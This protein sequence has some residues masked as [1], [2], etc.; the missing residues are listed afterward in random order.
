MFQFPDTPTESEWL[1]LI[2][3]DPEQAK[4]HESALQ[5]RIKREGYEVSPAAILS[6]EAYEA[7]Q[8]LLTSA[9]DNPEREKQVAQLVE[10]GQATLGVYPSYSDWLAFIQADKAF[11]RKLRGALLLKRAMLGSFES[12]ALQAS[13]EAYDSIMTQQG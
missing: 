8:Q 13:I 1:V 3:Q 11:A 2:Q 4:H 6:V 7:A 9:A 5:A 10:L 12:P